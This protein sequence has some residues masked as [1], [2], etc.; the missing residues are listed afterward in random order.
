MG[1]PVGHL[2]A[3]A[4]R[5]FLGVWAIGLVSTSVA[6]A[7]FLF[8][9]DTRVGYAI[10]ATIVVGYPLLVAVDAY[11]TAVRRRLE[12]RRWYQRWWTLLLIIA[13][14]YVWNSLAAAAIR[15]YAGQGFV[16]PTEGMSNT[17]VAGDYILADKL[18]YLWQGVRRGDVVVFVSNRQG[19]FL[20]QRVI[21]LPGDEVEVRDETVDVNGN[22]LAEPYAQLD[23][24]TAA[25]PELA[26]DGPLR[27]PEGHA[28]LLGDNRRASLD[29][30]MQGPV[31]ITS[32]IG[33]AHMIYWSQEMLSAD[34]VRRDISAPGPIRW[35]R[36]G[37]SI[38]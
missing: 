30:R 35:E 22:Q 24:H 34:P 12:E 18:R 9:P 23:E 37:Q 14:F 27:V 25:H 7:A 8:T 4:G 16:V 15:Q 29:S 13:G 2:Y 3:G 19:S 38:R 33:R 36:L 28:Y 32:I 26:N 6:I 17:I 10:L 5:R 20:V 31:P 21:G 1:G 11:R